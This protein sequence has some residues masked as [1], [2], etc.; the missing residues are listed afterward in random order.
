[1]AAKVPSNLGNEPVNWLRL[2]VKRGINLVSRDTNG[3]SDPYVK[4]R[5][6][7]TEYRTKVVLKTLDPVWDED[8]RMY[9]TVNTRICHVNANID[10]LAGGIDLLDY[11]NTILLPPLL[12]VIKLASMLT[13]WNLS[14]VH[15]LTLRW[16]NFI[17]MSQ[18]AL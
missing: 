5:V 18:W 8:F 6:G 2:R 1:M 13:L 11:T 15:L 4:C 3:K 9:L 7:T 17:E 10:P 16:W 14:S 12:T